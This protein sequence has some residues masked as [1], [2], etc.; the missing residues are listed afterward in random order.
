M[1]CQVPTGCYP[2]TRT[3][4]PDPASGTRRRSSPGLHPE[5]SSGRREAS[6]ESCEQSG[7]V[8]PSITSRSGGKWRILSRRNHSPQHSPIS[9]PPPGTDPSRGAIRRSTRRPGF[10]LWSLPPHDLETLS[11]STDPS[12]TRRSHRSIARSPD[13]GGGG[14][15]DP[16]GGTPS[17]V[18]RARPM[19]N[20]DR[21]LSTMTQE[22]YETAGLA[23]H[24]SLIPTWRVALNRR[25]GGPAALPTGME[26]NGSNM[27]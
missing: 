18:S 8:N 17:K 10:D 24:P 3:F 6:G 2:H 15:G 5:P 14:G 16:P 4:R 13:G 12:P 11:P 1:A 27:A 9:H 25:T 20:C 7:L 23:L 21:V 19:R 22:L 26:W